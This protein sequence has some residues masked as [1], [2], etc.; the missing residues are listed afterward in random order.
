M[1]FLRE[2]RIKTDIKNFIRSDLN[3]HGIFC[4]F[5]ESDITFVKILIIGPKDTPYENGFYFFSLKFPEN[6]PYSPP[7]LKSLTQH[8]NIRF[9]PN[10]YVD[11][12]VCL[13]ILGTWSGPGWSSCLTL[14]TVLLSVQSLLNEYPIQ[15][16]PG[17]EN[18]TGLR[19][20]N[21]NRIINY[22]NIMG[23]TIKML[24][25]TPDKFIE[26]KSVMQEYF[27]KNINYYRN[28]IKNNKILDKTDIYSTIYSL[29][30]YIDL[31]KMCGN[32]DNLYEKYCTDS[33]EIPLINKELSK[34]EKQNKKK[35]K[36]PS[37]LSK[38]HE[39]GYIMT[40]DNDNNVY[41]V[42]LVKGPKRTMK[43]WVRVK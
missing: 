1:N 10:L 3:T 36:C 26:F 13:S 35:T 6:Y 2:K 24:E 25:N 15:N 11:G 31:D 30:S 43:R 9:N 28:Y 37:D 22:N 32:I 20:K 19:S 12:K 23:A 33:K 7:H 4:Q 21:Y 8:H 17:F 5:D 14:N 39:I 40:S 27:I 16:E 38:N 18:E 41:K 42:M 34:I 29:H